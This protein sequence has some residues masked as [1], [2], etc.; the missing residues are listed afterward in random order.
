MPLSHLIPLLA[1]LANFIIAALVIT[2]DRTRTSNQFFGIFAISVALWSFSI[3][4]FIA[5]SHS[6]IL[7]IG[8]KGAYFFPLLLAASFYAFASVFPDWKRLSNTDTLIVLIPTMVVGA[9]LLI[10]EFLTRELIQASYGNA[11]VVGIPGYVTFVVTFLSFFIG[12]LYRIGRNITKATGILKVQLRYIFWGVLIA[13]IPAMF[14]NLFLTSPLLSN[15][16][17]IW[18]GPFFSFIMVAALA[19]AIVKYH[20][21]DVKVIVSEVFSSILTLIVFAELVA[22]ET[23]PELMAKIGMLILTTI[24]NFLLIRSVRGEVYQREELEITN[25]KLKRITETCV[26]DRNVRTTNANTTEQ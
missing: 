13:G 8:I 21:L 5:A 9:L 2:H 17:W 22:A 20:L 18:L 15:F 4:L 6:T 26:C 16:A 23:L 25:Q 11:I 14:T 24:I 7:L 1:A 3:G 12:G 10:P 19:R